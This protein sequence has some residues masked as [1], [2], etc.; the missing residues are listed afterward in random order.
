MDNFIK[1]FTPLE[2]ATRVKNKFCNR[3]GREDFLTGFKKRIHKRETKIAVVGL[4]YVGLPL[5]VEFAKCG[6]EVLGI[7]ID[8]DRINHIKRK[9]SY[10]SDVATKELRQTLNS[11][12]FSATN[13]FKALRNA[14]IIIICVPTPLKRKYHPDISYIKQAVNSIAQN[15]KKG[16][17]I[18]LES[19][20]YPGTTEDEVLP[21][22]ES[23]GLVCGKDF[24]LAF[25]PERID[26]GNT[27]Y[28]VNKIPKVIGGV[29]SEATELT[30]TVYR[31]IIDKVVP[32]S[33]SRVA[34]AVK[35]LE[36]TFRLINIGLIDE[37]AMMYHKMKIDIWEVIEA[38]KTKPFG[39]M[40]F[41]PGPGV[42]GHCIN[43]REFVWVKDNNGITINKISDLF[44]RFKSDVNS[45]K[46]TSY[47]TEFIR[48]RGLQTLSLDGED[49][50][51][52]FQN[53]KLLARRKYEGKSYDIVARDGR[54]ITATNRHPFFVVNGSFGVKFAED[55]VPGDR[56][57][58]ASRIPRKPGHGITKIDLIN[59]LKIKPLDSLIRM[60]P[61]G[62]IWKD[63][64]KI[65]RPILRKAGPYYCDF[66]RQNYI[67]FK[68]FTE[69]EKSGLKID[70]KNLLLCTGRGPSRVEISPII[71]IDED[72]CRLIGYYLSEG[73]LTEDESLR[74]R[75]SF[76]RDEAE[77]ISDVENI[78]T[79]LRLKYS[80]YHSK[81]FHTACI[82]VS[83]RIFGYLIR[84]VL[85]CG[86]NSYNMNIPAFL[87]NLPDNHLKQ[88]LTGLLRGDGGVCYTRKKRS[89]ARRGRHYCHWH[90]VA[91]ANYFSSSPVLFQQA[92][93]LLQH[94][95][96]VPTFKDKRRGLLNIARYN[97][98]KK[99]RE[100]FNGEK[101]GRL[102]KCV[103]NSKKIIPNRTF[104]RIGE[105]ITVPVAKVK[106]AKCDYVYSME[107]EKTNSFITSYGIAVHNCIP[108][109]PLY[110]Y[111]KGRHHGFKSRFIKLASDII[112]YMPEYVTER[113]INLLKK[114]GKRLNK[115]KLL[116]IGVTYKKDIKDLRKSPSLDI[117]DIFQKKNIAVSYYDP[118]IPYLKLNHINLKSISLNKQ[119][120]MK[121]DC[122]II[123][124]D[125]SSLDYEFLLNNSKLVF[126]TR[127]A[128]R[129]FKNSKVI[130]L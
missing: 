66:F 80:V 123:A 2:K 51:V 88:I 14:D 99:A 61:I 53:V 73:C 58:I 9:E 50:T 59:E 40:P 95:G 28:P 65:L 101:L 16:T 97:Q 104:G 76:N 52:K 7:D 54:K 37:L 84:D 67:P 18:I 116:V 25:S 56:L 62:F 72:F 57:V 93:A 44:G 38:A 110:L 83:S 29:T 115:I 8:K 129:N 30:V 26:P 21:L 119:Q 20:T 92:V 112:T 68:Y 108:K 3:R 6:F 126:D 125:H 4:G 63:Y 98:L 17:L 109:D 103:G 121:F 86:V 118:I 12:R 42:G 94:F 11:N 49:K 41:Y 128:Y 122:V 87:F 55:I 85:K 117:I 69:A 24:Y 13:N 39:F 27:R 82:K 96:I 70:H 89:Y 81:M 77:C 71:N 74:T 114:K 36:N 91:T 32:V 100:F 124:V 15:I 33:S 75:F 47:G 48:P 1:E 64:Q 107:V 106:E 78:L 102:N 22:L 105:I 111:W 46:R 90:M 10:I 23:K 113:V 127:N 34:E 19:T 5:A 120:L 31:N 43:G 45:Q 79:K 130:K 35:L 60:K